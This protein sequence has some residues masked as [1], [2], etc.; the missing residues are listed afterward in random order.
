MG[1][2]FFMRFFVLVAI[3]TKDKKSTAEKYFET[4]ILYHKNAENIRFFNKKI[5]HNICCK[6]A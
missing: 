6:S 4:L 1:I 2:S 5:K 3:H